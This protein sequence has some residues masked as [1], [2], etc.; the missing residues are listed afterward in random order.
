M[1]RLN[2]NFGNRIG[3]SLGIGTG[4]AA[5]LLI[6]QCIKPSS[7]L[8]TFIAREVECGY[9]RVSDAPTATVLGAE[10][11]KAAAAIEL[12]HLFRDTLS[13]GDSIKY[14]AL[15][16]RATDARPQAWGYREN[17]AGDPTMIDFTCPG[18]IKLDV[19]HRGNVVPGGKDIELVYAGRILGS[20]GWPDYTLGDLLGKTDLS[21]ADR[22]KMLEEG[23]AD[24]RAIHAEERRQYQLRFD[25]IRQGNIDARTAA[26]SAD[27]ALAARVRN[28]TTRFDDQEDGTYIARVRR[29]DNLVTISREFNACNGDGAFFPTAYGD[30][31]TLYGRDTSLETDRT[32]EQRDNARTWVADPVLHPGDRVRINSRDSYDLAMPT[33]KQMKPQ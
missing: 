13:T 32:V 26:L 4:L 16:L 9:E 23:A 28:C 27:P 24:A 3:R 10:D 12:D 15:E 29:G 7:T 2:L 22:R 31:D 30:L 14:G 6:Y 17:A 1:A 20:N 8:D 19:L 18:Y 5:A 11:P 33:P 25:A 21:R